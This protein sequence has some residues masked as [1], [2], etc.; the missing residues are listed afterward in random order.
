MNKYN[1]YEDDYGNLLRRVLTEGEHRDDRTGVGTTAI[2]G[3]SLK[4]DLREGFPILG[5]KKMS[6]KIAKTELLWML[7]GSTNIKM[8]QDN[9][10][11]IWDEWADDDGELGPVY[12]SQMRNFGGNGVDQI[13]QLI[14]GIKNNPTS[15]RHLVTMWN[16]TDLP[17]QKLPPCHYSF[18]CYVSNDGHL[19]LIFNM[20]SVDL[21]LGC[22]Y[23]M[24]LYGI[25]MHMIGNVTGLKP[26]Y[27][28]GNFADTHV[29]K[30]HK[31]AVKLYLNRGFVTDMVPQ[32]TL[33]KKKSIDDYTLDDIELINYFPQGVIKAPIAV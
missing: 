2:F 25:L 20:R 28:Q 9:G 23:D 4:A 22:P 32:L 3:A 10:I 29:Y 7:S 30:S 11:K 1:Q 26:R 14:D 31:N 17:N 6:I 18:S 15:R 24:A 21:Y 5:K 12:G 13:A 27:L 33:P 16:P 8:L 19:D